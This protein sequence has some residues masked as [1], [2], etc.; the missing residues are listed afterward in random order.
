MY[1]DVFGLRCYP[2]EDRADPQ[3]YYPVPECEEILASMEYEVHYGEGLCVVLGQAGTG[4]SML[5]RTFVKRLQAT[6]HVVVVTVPCGGRVNIIREI[7][8]GFGVSL[9]VSPHPRRSLARLRRHLSKQ[10]ETDHRFVIVVDQVENLSLDELTRIGGLSEL[11]HEDRRLLNILLVGQPQF[12][13]LFSQP[14][15][16]RLR[17]R[18]FG[19]RLLEPLSPEQTGEYIRHRLQVAGAAESS[20]VFAPDAVELIHEYTAGNPRIINRACNAALVAAYGAEQST[21]DRAIVEDVVKPRIQSMRAIAQTEFPI[22]EDQS[23]AAPRPEGSRDGIPAQRDKAIDAG[24][25]PPRPG[26]RDLP[27]EGT[28]FATG[29]AAGEPQ[30]AP[31]VADDAGAARA[32]PAASLLLSGGALMERLEQMTL[33]A[34]HVQAGHEAKV[35]QYVALEEHLESLSRGADGLVQRLAT[36]MGRAAESIEEV[37]RRTSHMLRSCETRLRDFDV[38]AERLT[39]SRAESA[40]HCARIEQASERAVQIESRL[41]TFAEELANKMENAQEKIALLMTSLDT[42]EDAHTRLQGAAKE[43]SELV[44]TSLAQ[45]T[46]QRD[47]LLAET[48]EAK[49]VR[50][51]AADPHLDQYRAQLSEVLDDWR[52]TQAAPVEEALAKQRLELQRL[53]EESTCHQAFFESL[54]QQSDSVRSRFGDIQSSLDSLRPGLGEAEARVTALNERIEEGVRELQD[55]LSRSDSAREELSE[56]TVQ[57]TAV[58]GALEAGTETGTTLL[59]DVKAAHGKIEWLREAAVGHLVEVGG[60]CERLSNARA[61]A[62][63]CE[64]LLEQIQAERGEHA[65]GAVELEERIAAVRREGE[66]LTD[67]ADRTRQ[68]REEAQALLH[69]ADEKMGQLSS[70][71]AAAGALLRQLTEANITGRE[72]LEQAN[73]SW[74]T[75]STRLSTCEKRTGEIDQALAQADRIHEKLRVTIEQ[76][77]SLVNSAADTHSRLDT[78]QRSAAASLVD[79]GAACERAASLSEQ[80][81]ESGK[82]VDQLATAG[83]EGLETQRQ[84]ANTVADAHLAHEALRSLALDADDKIRLID[85]RHAATADLLTDLTEAN[86]SGKKLVEAV[87]HLSETAG[88]RVESLHEEAVRIDNLTIQAREAAG[89]AAEQTETLVKLRQDVEVDTDLIARRRGD[90]H[91]AITQT[92]QLAE[93]VKSLSDKAEARRE[94]LIASHHEAESVLADMKDT[95]TTG[96]KVSA[97]LASLIDQAD[98]NTV[99]LETRCA[100]A[101]GRIEEVERQAESVSHQREETR[102][103]LER[104]EHLLREVR[105]MTTEAESRT[106]TLEESGS[107]AEALLAR[108]KDSTASLEQVSAG[109]TSL[110]ERAEDGT[111][112]LESKCGQADELVARLATMSQLIASAE[113]L[114]DTLS[115]CTDQANSSHAKL[116]QTAA[117]TDRQIEN[118]QRFSETSQRVIDGHEQARTDAEAAVAQL[119]HSTKALMKE[120]ET[121]QSGAETL[122]AR[123]EEAGARGERVLA[124]VTATADRALDKLSETE[125]IAERLAQRT[126][127]TTRRLDTHAHEIGERL[128]EQTDSIETGKTRQAEF[129]EQVKAFTE[130]LRTIEGRTRE[131]DQHVTEATMKPGEVIAAAQAQAAQLETVCS[132]VRKVFAGLSKTAID[133]QKQRETLEVMGREIEQRIATLQAETQGA[134]VALR[135]WVNEAIHAQSRLEQTLDR[136]PS[137]RETHPAGALARLSEA[138]AGTERA[139]PIRSSGDLRTLAPPAPEPVAMNSRGVISPPSQA[140]EIAQMIEEAK[141]AAVTAK[142]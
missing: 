65:R 67:I 123:I 113:K 121:Q 20:E 119:T 33:R 77:E 41:G 76:G 114:S 81:A 136:C 140:D 9:P 40:E 124:E 137:I 109:L 130:Q 94:E 61:E 101:T 19:E 43:I 4:K 37:E 29:D 91:E 106:A 78:L 30:W 45:V 23:E 24:L 46:E 89:E 115:N 27:E 18:A 110:V 135:Q 1:C 120:L 11:H 116:T 125:G 127:D 55:T 90:L 75:V 100:E 118:L 2:F 96:E 59:G 60:A 87:E 107:Q 58:R 117:Q 6:D 85:S 72:V 79:I 66:Q 15:F 31:L 5:V 138:S 34:E 129:E 99:M 17:Q 42:S 64:R 68:A 63:Q 95:T 86:T 98:R 83:A 132:A 111:T 25:H 26:E 57:A 54:K 122:L 142:K 14:D 38:R 12:I 3:F 32:A 44:T 50:A 131:L 13:T 93:E 53:S 39:R 62:A 108:L 112:E 21:V 102:Q 92:R 48:E 49:R 8:K 104:S 7:A 52:R 47:A 80:A 10:A 56:A 84:L 126:D 105:T 51:E 16:T 74:E 71:Q 69:A 70:H 22:T 36:S 28:D 97:G 134:S 73:E 88:Q 139:F 133:S 128:A 35:D 103:A 141:Q 82:V